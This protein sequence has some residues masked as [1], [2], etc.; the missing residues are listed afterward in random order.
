M[1][2][3]WIAPET[4]WSRVQAVEVVNGGSMRALGGRAETPLSGVPFWEAL[5][6]RGFRLTAIGGSDNHD[7]DLPFD[8]PSAIGRPTTVIWAEALSQPALL[9]GLRAGRAFVDLDGDR[10][11]SL[12]FSAEADGVRA[13][14]GGTL[15][16][17]AA[18]RFTVRAGGV[19]GGRIE[20][21]RDGRPMEIALPPLTAEA[22]PRAFELPIDGARSW[23]R[24]NVRDADGRLI[25]VGN[26]IYLNR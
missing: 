22:D 25:L 4:D 16:A 11:R 17:P 10:S 24:V 6:N 12:E 20:V 3:G 2:C 14:M 8:T 1:G 21:V 9:E 13:E 26:P 19:D 15:A 5:L 18:V 23:V 7:A